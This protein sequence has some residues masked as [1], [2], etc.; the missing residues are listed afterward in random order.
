[1]SV[2]IEEVLKDRSLFTKL[3]IEP[4]KC[5]DCKIP[6]QEAI[7]GKRWTATGFKCSDCYFGTFG[8][9]IEQS[10]ITIG[11]VRRG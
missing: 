1:M 5:V 4:C 11:R 6:L 8:D 10:P 9:G 2:T 7:T 3:E